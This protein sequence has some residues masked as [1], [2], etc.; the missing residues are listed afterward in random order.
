MNLPF[1]WKPIWLAAC[2]SIGAASIIPSTTLAAT[3]PS[4][5]P[6]E[7]WAWKNG[8]LP[9]ALDAHIIGS[10]TDDTPIRPAAA[11]TEAEALNMLFHFFTDT[12]NE[13]LTGEHLYE[14][15][16]R[17]NLPVAVNPNDHT[18]SLTRGQA[19]RLL[20]AVKG[21]NYQTDSAIAFLYEKGLSQGKTEKTIEGFDAG[22][23]ISRVEFVQLLKGMADRKLDGTISTCPQTEST[24]PALDNYRRT[25]IGTIQDNLRRA[26]TA[27]SPSDSGYWTD[28]LYRIAKQT[29][30]RDHTLTIPLPTLGKDET[31]TY[32]VIADNWHSGTYTSGADTLTFPASGNWSATLIVS[33]GNRI[34][35]DLSLNS[36]NHAIEINSTLIEKTK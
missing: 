30:V 16:K 20:A 33:Q 15:A 22:S 23:V 7:H 27:Y 9:W 18:K 11:V 6:A 8:T 25:Q 24:H 17:Y 32:H 10:A 3:R 2:L 26:K 36:A 5:V 1:N 13:D 35:G 4:D 29:T 28:T 21:Y 12:Q 14:L 34:L 19:A 31:I